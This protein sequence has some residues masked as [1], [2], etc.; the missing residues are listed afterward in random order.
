MMQRSLFKK[1]LVVGI[2]ILFVGVTIASGFSLRI[3]KSSNFEVKASNGELVKFPVY[4]CRPNGI[5]DYEVCI[6][7]Q[8]VEELDNL[9]YD[10]KQKLKYIETLEETSILFNDTILSLYE[11][12]VIPNEISIDE[13]QQLVTGEL[14]N[15]KSQAITEMKHTQ[16]INMGIQS[17]GIW[18]DLCFIYSN[19]TN[20]GFWGRF[21]FGWYTIDPQY[22][23]W[24]EFAR[25]LVWTNGLSG[26]QAME[27]RF[28]GNM[29]EEISILSDPAEGTSY[30]YVGTIGLIGVSIPFMKILFG[31]AIAAKFIYV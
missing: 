21:Y 4:I 10:F 26:I 1:G 19:A 27:G 12:G 17:S 20:V 23:Y 11:L 9:I 2:I 31:F 14:Y 5:E 7:Q 13:A 18:N 15:L 29:G 3:E 28:K 22:N 24:Y 25:G 6:T 8:Q 30:G 16:S